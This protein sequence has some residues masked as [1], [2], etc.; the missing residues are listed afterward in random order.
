MSIRVMFYLAEA[1]I[2]TSNVV[3]PGSTGLP[4]F[5]RTC[6]R[7]AAPAPGTV[8]ELHVALTDAFVRREQRRTPARPAGAAS[9]ACLAPPRVLRS[10]ADGSG[11]YQGPAP[12]RPR[13]RRRG[14][15]GGAAQ[16]AR[17]RPRGLLRL[18]R[19]RDRCLRARRPDLP[20]QA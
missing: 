13:G 18:R 7:P 17:A 15:R 2:V 20:L 10:A 4:G 11:A 3:V 8:P 14:S 19:R 12:R 1:P 16:A 6:E 5:E 9:A